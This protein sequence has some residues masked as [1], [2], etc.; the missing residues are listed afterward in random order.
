MNGERDYSLLRRRMVERLMREGVIKSKKVERAF[1]TVPR[2]EFVWPNTKSLA[3]EDTPLPLGI[4]GQTISAP[5][6]VAIM[7]EEF[8]LKSGL[9]I[10]EI[11]TGSGYNA[12]LMAEI[13][14]P[15]GKDS[16]NQGHVITIER[17]PELIKFSKDNFD[18]TGYSDRIDVV[19]GD[20][21][22]GYPE[23][24]KKMLYDRIMVTAAAPQI[25]YY[26]KAQ[27]KID[28]IILAPVGNTFMQTLVKSIKLEGG[29]MKIEEICGCIFVSLIGEDGFRF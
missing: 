14:R 23:R 25:P 8:D 3:Y 26:L 9:R 11:G 17:V 15:T 20:G 1:L 2:E 18:R 21:T 5:H 12:A 29:K 4:T 19:L 6:M 28:G 27:L 7:L 16:I 10:L 24:S 22:L 13:V